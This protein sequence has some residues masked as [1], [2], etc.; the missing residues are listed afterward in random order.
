MKLNCFI[1]GDAVEVLKHD[2]RTERTAY[3]TH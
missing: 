2:S 3:E 1:V